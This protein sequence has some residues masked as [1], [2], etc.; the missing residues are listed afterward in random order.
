MTQAT[1]LASLASYITANS[2]GT[3]SISASTTANSLTTLG[4]ITSASNVYGTTGA[5]VGV[6][7]GADSTYGTNAFGSMNIVSE[8]A[9]YYQ[10]AIT[11][12]TS[13][14]INS[15]PPI[16]RVRITS[17]GNLIV[18]STTPAVTA[19]GGSLYFNGSSYLSLPTG[20]GNLGSGAW[21]VE[22]FWKSNGAEGN[23]VPIISQNFTGS[24]TSGT[25]AFKV[26]NT[27]QYVAFSWGTSPSNLGGTTNIN[28]SNW[29]HLAVVSTGS[30]VTLYVDGV[31]QASQAIS[32]TFGSTGATTYIGYEPRDS[33][34][35]VGY[36]SNLRVVSGTAV[37][38]ANFTPPTSALTAITGTI[39][40][41]NVA[42]S[43]AYLTD[44]STNNYTSTATGTVTYIGQTPLYTSAVAVNG[45]VGISNGLTV[46]GPLTANSSV[47]IGAGITGSPA[48]TNGGGFIL[49]SGWDSPASSHTIYPT[50]TNGDN[51]TG[52][53]IV[54]ATNKGTPGKNGTILINVLKQRGSGT[55][56]STVNTNKTSNLTTL[57]Y[58]QSGD[59]NGIT[60]STDSDCSV[61][62]V[63][64]GGA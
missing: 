56:Y 55:Y 37:Y 60:V 28:D 36:L 10:G 51:S 57:T 23:F 4:G 39:L 35:L 8:L 50:P 52:L 38:T 3:I 21:T 29:H 26:N 15:A 46:G 12:L 44:S 59:T 43:G 17:V 53:L 19:N 7:R 2:N 42:S 25:W 48:V 34:Y 30:V 20:A 16:E 64:I 32:G 62:W 61:C 13:P 54:N 45:G 47:S 14:N 27:G 5:T 11:F 22:C 1:N 9:N 58:T 41:L 33:S 49:T 6:F 63:L 40:L 24:T 31:S 18:S